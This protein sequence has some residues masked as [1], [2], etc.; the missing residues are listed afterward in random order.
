M[1]DKLKL[2][3]SAPVCNDLAGDVYAMVDI[4]FNDVVLA[5]D[6]QLSAST[7]T[8]EY[9]VTVLTDANNVLNIELTNAVAS[10]LNS[11]GEFSGVGEATVATIEAIDYSVDDGATWKTVTPVTGTTYTVPAGSHAGAEVTLIQTITTLAVSNTAT[12]TVQF[13]ANGVVFSESTS[14][15]LLGT[16]NWKNDDGF[17]VRLSDNTTFDPDG[18]EV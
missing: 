8:V 15:G 2:Q 7:A 11:D 3:L 17:V 18:N 1:S 14:W 12:G 4:K 10:D 6:V 5:E 13:N 9:D 16:L